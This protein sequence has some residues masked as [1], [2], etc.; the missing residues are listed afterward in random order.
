[1]IHFE[2]MIDPGHRVWAEEEEDMSD[3]DEDT[4][5]KQMQNREYEKMSNSQREGRER[6]R[7]RDAH[8]T[9][10]DRMG[11]EGLDGNLNL[12]PHL[13]PTAECQQAATL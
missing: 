7:I 4:T 2:G 10:H 11:R 13:H 8:A 9:Q 5:R 3:E 6:S 1:M 12:S